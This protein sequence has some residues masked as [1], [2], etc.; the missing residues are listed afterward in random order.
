ML[1][2]GQPIILISHIRSTHVRIN[3]PGDKENSAKGDPLHYT[4]SQFI[5]QI[6]YDAL[7]IINQM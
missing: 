2:V 6:P 7:Q 5:R 4:E 1:S 3:M